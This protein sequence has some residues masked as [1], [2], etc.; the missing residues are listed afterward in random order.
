MLKVIFCSS[1]FWSNCFRHLVYHLVPYNVEKFGFA[2][3]RAIRFH[4]KEHLL[5]SNWIE[6][7]MFGAPPDD[8]KKRFSFKLINR[9]RFLC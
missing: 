2:F 9:I 7:K 8:G 3:A 4:F 6:T 5:L 1:F